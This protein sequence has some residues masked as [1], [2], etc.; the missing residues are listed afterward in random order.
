MIGTIVVLISV[1]LLAVAAHVLL[2]MGLNQLGPIGFE[3]MSDPVS[4]VLKTVSNSFLVSA[5]PLYGASLVAWSVVL[6]RMQLS[7]AYPALSLTYIVI[8]F[9]SWLLLNEP[10]S[11][12]HWV[13]IL[14][15]AIGVFLVLMGGLF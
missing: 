14:V 13:G 11:L 6:S 10:I 5:L 12:I 2:K 8:P 1:V 15:V 3:Q 9:V 7:V 4:L